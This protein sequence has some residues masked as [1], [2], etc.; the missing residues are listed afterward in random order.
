MKKLVSI[1]LSAAL[2]FVFSGCGK[3]NSSDGGEKIEHSVEV[4]KLAAA[5]QI[6]EVEFLVGDP[7]DGVKNELFKLSSGMTYEDFCSE[8]KAS[9]N[10]LQGDMYSGYVSTT[11]Q[12]GY[13]VLSSTYNEY[14]SV[15]CIYPTDKENAKIS[16]IAVQGPAYGFD[17]SS[18]KEYVK[19]A[20]E[21]KAE[22]AEITSEFSFIPKASEGATCL[23]YEFG[24]YRLE[25]YFSPY[26]E[27]SLTV[28]YD[29]N[30][31]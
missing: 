24:A 13:T 20:V 6:P 12:N 14:N 26:D 27:L 7:V 19:S 22:E 28:L 25:F 23:R 1:I 9:G 30:L 3:N 17:N 4:A 11:E 8:V 10:E 16:A 15:Y 18:M 2:I 5:G 31:H 21:G 29:V